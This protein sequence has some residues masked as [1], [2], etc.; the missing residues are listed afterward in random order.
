[1]RNTEWNARY[2]ADS[3]PWGANPAQLLPSLL[4]ATPP[5]GA[6][7]DVAC[8]SGRNARWLATLGWAVTAVDFSESAIRKGQES[9]PGDR[10]T[11]AVADVTQ[12]SPAG[13]FDLVL[14][15]YLHLPH[16]ILRA[17]LQRAFTWL[18]PAGML[19]YLGH[20]RENVDR[21]TGGPQDP[22]VLP[23]IGLLA[24][25]ASGY[26]VADLRHAVRATPNGQAID[27]VL[28][29]RPWAESAGV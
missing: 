6:A 10:I 2:D 19:L 16:D 7:L 18:T 15:S 25:A 20:A 9:D 29:A 13:T 24:E 3:E 27:V 21:G 23:D 12:W 26:Q 4:D 11:W 17:V 28:K 8:G 1:M 5:S 14:F 22:S